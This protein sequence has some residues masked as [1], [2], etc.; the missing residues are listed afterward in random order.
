MKIYNVEKTKIL[1]SCDLEKGYLQK[2][3]LIKHISAVEEIKEQYHYEIIK[4]YSNGGND[5]R[6]VV[7]VVGVTGIPEHDEYEDILIY[8]PYTAK[9]LTHKEN[10]KVLKEYTQWF[11]TY[12]QM[13]L[14][15]H[16]WQ[17]DY[18]PSF[19]NY[20]NCDYISWEDVCEKAQFVR[21]EINK[22]RNLLK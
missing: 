9:E 17:T 6:K 20:F 5:V 21:E 11:D 4:T 22:L 8:I 12:F 7:D 14:Q 1:E 15:Q 10:E 16:S 2:D 19:D 3:K 18:T 13:Q